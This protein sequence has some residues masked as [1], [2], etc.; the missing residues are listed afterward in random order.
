MQR[1]R[2]KQQNEN[3]R[4][5]LKKVGSIKGTF[6][7]RMGMIK[8]RNGKDL[9]E[10]DEIKNRQQ[11]YTQ[12]QKKGHNDLDNQ[13]GVVSHVELDILGMK[14]SGPQEASL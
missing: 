7:A 2:G 10:A 1:N 4:D 9:T 12:L 14:S 11:E 3:I 13:D 6:H 8:D 5:L